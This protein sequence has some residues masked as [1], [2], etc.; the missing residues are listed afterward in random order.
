MTTPL[1]EALLRPTAYPHPAAPVEVIETHISWVLLAGPYAYK[2]KK[3]VILPFADFGSLA[4]RRRLCRE[5]VRLNRRFAASVYLGVVPITGS[6]EHPEVEGRGRAIEYAVKM[7]RF[8]QDALFDHLLARGALA[9]AHID[10]LATRIAEFH[11]TARATRST[12]HGTPRQVLRPALDNFPALAVNADPARRAQLHELEAWTR[13]EFA[14]CRPALAARHRDGWI[15]ECHGDLHLRNIALIDGEPTPFD[16]IEFNPAFRWIDVIDEAAFLVM[17]LMD[18]GRSDLGYRFLDRYLAITGDY[19]GIAV[20]RFYLV[21][22]ALV[23]AKVHD[24][25]ARQARGD[26]AEARRLQAAVDHYLRLALDIVQR[27]PV[28]LILMHGLSGSGKSRI[29]EALLEALGALRLRSDVE[30]K[31]LHGLAS[32]ASSGSELNAGIYDRS[33]STRT[34]ARLAELAEPIALAGYPVIVDAAFL[35]RWQRDAMYALAERL[36]VPA[37]IVACEAPVAVLRERIGA[38]AAA[39]TDPSEATGAVLDGQIASADPL[40]AS[41]AVRSIRCDT[42]GPEASTVAA[43]VTGILRRLLAMNDP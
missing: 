21:Y 31:R 12:R 22:R 36:G 11:V 24:L 25:R 2:L 32:G 18:R 28:Q 20:L 37:W 13:A 6:V 39:R 42:R 19:A 29:A 35:A 15:R 33:A 27:H 34:Y 43:C 23:R 17:D 5:E 38:R 7:R 8:G 41:E 16:C 40:D 30:R 3:P 10:R 26:P 14:R 4:R 1:I 9:A